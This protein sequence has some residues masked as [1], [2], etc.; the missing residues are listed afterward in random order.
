MNESA[1]NNAR[2]NRGPNRSRNAEPSRSPFPTRRERARARASQQTP[3]GARSTDPRFARNGEHLTTTTG[4][5]SRRLEAERARVRKRRRNRKIRAGLIIG[6]VVAILAVCLYFALNAVWGGKTPQ[7]ST[8]YAGPGTGEVQFVVNPG[9]SGTIIGA[10]M[11]EKNIVKTQDA[12]LKAWNDNAAAATVK[13]GTYQMKKQMRAVDAVAALLDDTKR[14]SNAVTVSPGMSN[15]LIAQRLASF[16]NFDEKTVKDAMR[17]AQAL[18]LPKVANGNSEGWL[19]PGSYEVHQDDSVQSV[20]KQMVDKTK[21][22]L[23]NYNVPEDKQEELLIK[24]SILEREVNIK[25]YLPQVARVIDNRLAD[26]GGQTAGLLQMDSTVN[27]ALGR[28]SGVPSLDDLKVDSPYNTYKHKG[29]PPGPIAAPSEDAI[30]A[31]LEP[32]K[33]KWLYFVTVNLDSGETIFTNTRE[34]H[35]Q[36]QKKLQDWCSANKGKC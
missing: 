28:Q 30:E 25:K 32:A 8:D 33:G 7:E 31:T 27:Y 13:P 19:S 36:A 18:G 24:A 4:L 2:Q 29:L 1:N 21:E 9:D 20:L 17:D 34:E 16:A 22:T 35:E 6:V 5:R 14:S 23:S 26:T 10:N 3:P 15:D 11:V 12:F